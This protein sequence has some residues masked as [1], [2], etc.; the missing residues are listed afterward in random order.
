M[1]K[2]LSI[3]FALSMSSSYAQNG[4]LPAGIDFHEHGHYHFDG[5]WKLVFNEDFNGNALDANIWSIENQ[6]FTATDHIQNL[7]NNVNVSNGICTLKISEL[8]PGSGQSTPNYGTAKISTRPENGFD[9]ERG[10]FQ[11]KIKMP[12]GFFNAEC[13]WVWNNSSNGKKSPPEASEIDIAECNGRELNKLPMY[14]HRFFSDPPHSE[15]HY[16]GYNETVV[17]FGDVSADFHIYTVIWDKYYMY[18][19]LDFD[20]N[21]PSEPVLKIS[22]L[23][24]DPGPFPPSPFSWY[25]NVTDNGIDMDFY[26]TTA[27]TY[28]TKQSFFELNEAGHIILNIDLHDKKIYPAAQ[29]MLKQFDETYRPM[30]IDWVRVYKRDV[31]EESETITNP[32]LL[33]YALL[34]EKQITLQTENI[35]TAWNNIIPNTSQAPIRA[36]GYYKAEAILMLPNFESYPVYINSYNPLTWNSDYRP[37]AFSY[38]ARQCPV[39]QNEYINEPYSSNVVIDSEYH[40]PVFDCSQLDTAGIDS[41]IQKAIA[42]Q[43]TL[44][45][46][47]I[48]SVLSNMGCD[49]FN[50]NKL[51]PQTA[52]AKKMHTYINRSAGIFTNPSTGMFTNTNHSTSIFTSTN[53]KTSTGAFTYPNPNTGTF[54]VDLPEISTFDIVITNMLGMEVYKEKFKDQRRTEISLNRLLPAGNYTIYI[55]S[56]DF[57]HIEKLS[58]IR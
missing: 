40:P 28:Y 11:A 47:T 33:P 43:D 58:I 31:C 48:Y 44:T 38:V 46:D 39:S 1:R 8:P 2:I 25:T 57:R 14:T 45:L 3:F 7:S 54:T 52:T 35:N 51:S 56:K 27:N 53:S 41:M 20:I 50:G 5:K 36:T 16:K 32:T 19:Y 13:F 30:Q 6:T 4:H 23:N 29:Q 22:K 12:R 10:M 17:P 15:D 26:T 9:W 42:N 24:V 21:N 49:L 18:F 55:S 37:T 34:D